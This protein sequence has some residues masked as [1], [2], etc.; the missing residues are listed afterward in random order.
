MRDERCQ[1]VG[2]SF[3]CSHLNTVLLFLFPLV[4]CQQDSWKYIYVEPISMAER[5]S[6]MRLVCKVSSNP[7]P[8]RLENFAVFHPTTETNFYQVR[9]VFRAITMRSHRSEAK[10][11]L[12]VCVLKMTSF[13]YNLL[14]ALAL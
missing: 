3:V 13:K 10:Q 8:S 9:A 12:G 7:L 11:S 1:L 2:G 5:D 6:N 4:A 14:E